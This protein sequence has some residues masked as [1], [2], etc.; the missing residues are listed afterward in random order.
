MPKPNSS[1]NL[2]LNRIM[3]RYGGKSSLDRWYKKADMAIETSKT[4]INN[5]MGCSK[6]MGKLFNECDIYGS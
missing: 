4:G 3:R 1:K 2:K 6:F 5:H